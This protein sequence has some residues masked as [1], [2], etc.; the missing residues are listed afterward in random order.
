MKKVAALFLFITLT[1]VVYSQDVKI[2]NLRYHDQQPIHFGFT[3]GLNYMDFTI[4]KSGLFFNDT[5]DFYGI[6]NGIFP[7][8]H[9]GPIVNVRMGQY[10][11]LRLLIDLSFGQRNLKY[12]I[13]NTSS[14]DGTAL[15]TP[16][17]MQLASTFIET[18]LLIKYKAARLN[19]MR[20]YIIFGG[21]PKYD[22]SAR[23]KPKDSELPKIQLIEF[24][25]YAD[26]GFGIDWYLEYFKL[27][28]E[29]K[30]S[31]GFMNVL[32]KDGTIYSSAIDKMTSKMFMLS[33]HFE[34][35]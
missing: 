23:K 1:V 21:N 13:V 34:G 24:D 12:S 31:L 32:E 15:S 28:T 20:P 26:I 19:N 5:V 35:P 10:F 11:D 18:P 16:V 3:V 4:H 33:F 30:Y 27:S 17:E 7:G 6:E 8:F 22:L 9:L 2:K 29:L 25:M 14:G